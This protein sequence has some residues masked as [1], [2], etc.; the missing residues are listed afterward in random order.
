MSNKVKFLR[1]SVAPL[2]RSSE[3]K[4]QN[5]EAKKALEPRAAKL[6]SER[7]VFCDQPKAFLSGTS[8]QVYSFSTL[9]V[10]VPSPFVYNVEVNRPKKMN[11]LNK[12][13]PSMILLFLSMLFM[14]KDSLVLITS[15]RSR[16]LA[17]ILIK[18][19]PPGDVGRDGRSIH[20]VEHRPRL[21]CGSSQCS[22]KN[23][24]RRLIRK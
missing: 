12:V 16:I 17:P 15:L 1:G 24:Q 3:T 10:T 2:A 5:C 14:I 4:L 19:I 7:R 23:V 13:R 21:S 20:K 18:K 22:W 8:G 11:A 6:H 9:N